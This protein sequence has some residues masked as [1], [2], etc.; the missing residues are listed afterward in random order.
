MVRSHDRANLLSARARHALQPRR[1]KFE[2]RINVRS[3]NDDPVLL[4]RGTLLH[5]IEERQISI[6]QNN[7]GQ[8]TQNQ[9]ICFPVIFRCLF[10]IASAEQGEASGRTRQFAYHQNCTRSHMLGGVFRLPFPNLY[11]IWSSLRPSLPSSCS[12]S[13]FLQLSQ[14][15]NRPPCTADRTCRTSHQKS[16]NI[17]LKHG[18]VALSAQP[19]TQLYPVNRNEFL[20]HQEY[21][22]PPVCQTPDARW[23]L[24]STNEWRFCSISLC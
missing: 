22:P 9:R 12:P 24:R 18:E 23:Q 11:S 8:S 1:E 21:S 20:E 14:S 16:L 2:T 3:V 7:N 4:S 13:A 6:A 10:R 17:V 15:P 19:N 5:R